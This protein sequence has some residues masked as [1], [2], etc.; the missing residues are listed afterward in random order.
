MFRATIPFPGLVPSA[1][2]PSVAVTLGELLAGCGGGNTGGPGWVGDFADEAVLVSA[3][4]AEVLHA[5]RA[6]RAGGYEAQ[7]VR[8][9]A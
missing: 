8:R 2:P 7:P 5:S 9:A 3:D 4:L 6:L 1:T